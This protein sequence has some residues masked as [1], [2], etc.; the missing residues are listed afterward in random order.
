MKRQLEIN[1][2][3]RG[4]LLDWLVEVHLKFKLFPQ[5]LYLTVH[6]IDRYLQSTQ[7]QRGDLQ[8]VG[9]ASLLIASKYEEIYSPELRDFTYISDNA[10]TKQQILLMEG[11]ILDALE[12]NLT[13]TYPIVFVKRFQKIT[14][15]PAK[16]AMMTNYLLELGLIHLQLASLKPSQQAF[17]AFYLACKICKSPESCK[18]VHEW[19]S[20]NENEV[21]VIAL[22][23]VQLWKNENKKMG[24]CTSNGRLD[25]VRRKYSAPKFLQIA[26]IKNI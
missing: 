12:F 18:E 15:V 5:T 13:T 14:K 2:R 20:V 23:Y 1:E 21:K 16:V 17:G 11:A 6:I 22:K 4:I 8:L 19:M 3:M 7:V 10:Y 9:L 25:A 24:A 26:N